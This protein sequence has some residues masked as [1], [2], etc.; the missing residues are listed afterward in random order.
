MLP[1]STSL[2][3]ASCRLSVPLE[4]A[5]VRRATLVAAIDDQLA[6]VVVDPEQLKDAGAAVE[7]GVGAA[8]A[9]PA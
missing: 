4:A 5:A 6:E 3:A 7:A 1:R 2:Q 8:R 9:T